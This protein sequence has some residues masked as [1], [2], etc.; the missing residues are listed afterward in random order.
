MLQGRFEDAARC[1]AEAG[2]MDKAM[3]VFSHMKLYDAGQKWALNYAGSHREA[4]DATIDTA[5]HVR[6]KHRVTVQNLI[7]SA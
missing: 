5:V 3:D 6:C 4:A 7:C 1:Y 2:K